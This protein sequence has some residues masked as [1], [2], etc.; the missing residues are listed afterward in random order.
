MDNNIYEFKNIQTGEVF[1]A[2]RKDLS[3]KYELNLLL[4]GQI[5][6]GEKK[7]YKGWSCP[8]TEENLKK[9]KLQMSNTKK[10][11]NKNFF[12][13]LAKL[14]PEIQDKIRMVFKELNKKIKEKDK[15]IAELEQQNYK[16]NKYI[17]D[18]VKELLNQDKR[19]IELEEEVIEI[20]KIKVLKNY[21]K[22][23]NN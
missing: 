15:K 14:K 5:V 7:S 21:L 2:T 16:Q 8:R 4:I 22:N 12:R 18:Q 9:Y 20:K 1:K 3:E 17:E 6:R 13:T 23:K 11:K 19:I 10:N